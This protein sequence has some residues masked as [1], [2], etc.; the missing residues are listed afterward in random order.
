MRTTMEEYRGFM[1]T[2]VPQRN[3]R[4]QIDVVP[5]GGGGKVWATELHDTPARALE[6]A[7]LTIDR[8]V[9]GRRD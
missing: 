3:G 7:K 1:L 8:T 9:F 5:V 4:F 2:V 6:M